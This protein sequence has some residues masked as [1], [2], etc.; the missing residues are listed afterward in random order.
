MEEPGDRSRFLT[1]LRT[2]PAAIGAAVRGVSEARLRQAPFP[3]EWS[4][5]EILAHLRACADVWGGCIARQLTEDT[6]VLRAVNPRSYVSQTDYARLEFA[7]SLSAYSE[8]R[9][10]LLDVLDALPPEAWDRAAIIK[11]A[12][13]PLTRT[14]YSYVDR[15]ARHEHRHLAQIA[16]AVPRR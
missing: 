12:G 8:Q 7:G 6:P 15:M 14:V 4:A 11:G 3:G 9:Q 16:R 1:A 5:L 2:A 10:A 13:G